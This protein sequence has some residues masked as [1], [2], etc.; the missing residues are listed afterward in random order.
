MEGSPKVS[1]KFITTAIVV[2][3]F[4]L[5]LAIGV[6]ALKKR[7]RPQVDPNVYQAVFLDNNQQYFGHLK[8]V[9]GR[10]PYLTDIYYVRM[11]GPVTENPGQQQF[12]LIKFGSEIH[13]PEDVMYINWDKVLYWENLKPESEVVKGIYKEKA[14]RANPTPAPAP[15]PAPVPAR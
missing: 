1:E 13:G 3:L 15:A 6:S 10:F 5:L 14:Q 2:V 8:N 7:G 4:V 12:S 9:G 11:Q